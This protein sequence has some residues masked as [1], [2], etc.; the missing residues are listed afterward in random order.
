[1]KSNKLNIEAIAQ[2]IEHDAGEKLDGL[3]ESL[4][5]MQQYRAGKGAAM[6]KTQ[7]QISPIIEARNR[8]GLTQAVFAKLMGVSVRTLQE[9]EQGRRNPSG[10]AQTLLR[11][12]KLQ[13]ETLRERQA[14]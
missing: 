8:V 3:R 14:M 6:R 4:N 11:I 10:A 2:A 5:E 7:V 12:A 13:P 1:M 9:W